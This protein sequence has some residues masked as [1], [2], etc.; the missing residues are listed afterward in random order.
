MDRNGKLR[1]RSFIGMVCS[2]I[3]AMNRSHRVWELRWETRR[4]LSYGRQK[5]KSHGSFL[6]EQQAVMLN[7][8]STPQSTPHLPVDGVSFLPSLLSRPQ[9]ITL[10]SLLFE[11]Y[12][13]QRTKRSTRALERNT[14]T[15]L[16]HLD[17]ESSMRHRVNDHR[18]TKRA[19][20]GFRCTTR[21]C[22]GRS[23]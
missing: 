4:W 13:S 9:R 17:S 19:R 23:K 3:F 10:S 18:S 1:I 12:D 14:Q 5:T 8:T 22:T 6:T 2:L 15:W 21:R 16:G 7:Q 11:H 20:R